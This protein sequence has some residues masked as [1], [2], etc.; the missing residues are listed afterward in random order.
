LRV[1]LLHGRMDDA[2]KADVMARFRDRQIDL[3]VCTT[4][5]EVGVDVPNATWLIVEHA[6]RFGLSQLH[7]L[8]GRVSRGTEA[9]VCVLFGEPLTDEGKQRLRTMLQT[10]DGFALAEEDARLRGAGDVFSARQH[11]T[12][13]LWLLAQARMDL[14]ER[15]HA[16]ARELVAA[17]LE[18]HP[19]LRRAVMARY[20]TALELA[21]VG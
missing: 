10:A 17:G 13:E 2:V 18:G 4:V 1:G 20:G 7:Q 15:A 8:R 11:G 21:G 14:L 19:G 12:G 16:D 6:E 5:V 3:L 9:G